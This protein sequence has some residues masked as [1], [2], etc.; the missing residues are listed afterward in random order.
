LLRGQLHVSTVN[1]W[2][3]SQP[4]AAPHSVGHRS[5]STLYSVENNFGSQASQAFASRVRPAGFAALATQSV[6]AQSFVRDID[7]GCFPTTLLEILA[8]ARGPRLFTRRNA[9]AHFC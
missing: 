4:P 2:R 5:Y 3:P 1:G 7:H 6:A 8:L 9:A